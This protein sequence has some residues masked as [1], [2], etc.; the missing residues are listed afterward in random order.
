MIRGEE[1]KIVHGHWEL[2]MW[3][4]EYGFQIFKLPMTDDVIV[5]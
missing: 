5:V 2:I 1:K 4:M 3:Q